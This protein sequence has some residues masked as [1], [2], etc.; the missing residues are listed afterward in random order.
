MVSMVKL[1][2]CPKFIEWKRAKIVEIVKL[3]QK[4]K[5]GQY[6]KMAKWPKQSNKHWLR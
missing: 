5:K 6:D 1:A 4:Y 3:T 2:K